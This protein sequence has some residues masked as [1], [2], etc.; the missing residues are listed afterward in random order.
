VS[1]HLTTLTL[2]RSELAEVSEAI[3]YAQQTA[4]EG[5]GRHNPALSRVQRKLGD[6]VG[7]GAGDEPYS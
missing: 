4:H 1:R 7:C 6:E 5:A 2:T 3:R